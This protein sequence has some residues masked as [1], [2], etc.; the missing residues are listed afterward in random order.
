MTVDSFKNTFSSAC[1]K[2]Q[3]KQISAT[4]LLI[5]TVEYIHTSFHCVKLVLYKICPSMLLVK[6]T[7]MTHLT[8]PFLFSLKKNP[9][10]MGSNYIYTKN[11]K[12]GIY[13]V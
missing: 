5:Y 12:K 9:T 1:A 11:D 7:M 2:K 8:A 10:K 3:E 13:M 6:K 4:A